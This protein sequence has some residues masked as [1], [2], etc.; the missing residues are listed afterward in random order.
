MKG[1]PS[2]GPWPRTQVILATDIWLGLMVDLVPSLRNSAS[3]YVTGV[4][5]DTR[6][7]QF[8]MS[9][10]FCSH[11]PSSGFGYL[12]KSDKLGIQAHQVPNLRHLTQHQRNEGS[13]CLPLLPCQRGFCQQH[14]GLDGVLDWKGNAEKPGDRDTTRG[15]PQDG[16]SEAV[17]RLC[18]DLLINKA[19][20][21]R[22]IPGRPCLQPEL[23]PQNSHGGRRGPY[24]HKLL[25]SAV[26]CGTHTNAHTLSKLNFNKKKLK[27]DCIW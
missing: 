21:D 10:E 1:M 4:N 9:S 2:L 19:F 18:C 12:V 8:P 17:C 7:T 14:A 26:C 16:C 25:M 24:S 27:R 5:A 22:S 6:E 20:G 13:V 23:D 3:S 15:R 11:V